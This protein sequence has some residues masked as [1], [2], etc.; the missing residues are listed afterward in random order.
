MIKSGDYASLCPFCTMW[1]TIKCRKCAKVFKSRRSTLCSIER[2]AT[3]SQF[4]SPISFPPRSSQNMTR[5]SKEDCFLPLNYYEDSVL[6]RATNVHVS[7]NKFH[8][9]VEK[10]YDE[11][12]PPNGSQ[13]RC[14]LLLMNESTL[15]R[16]TNTLIIFDVDTNRSFFGPV[17]LTNG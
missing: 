2:T 10:M 8:W 6:N 5:I 11:M 4:L 17:F 7:A 15:S 16:A 12:L 14:Q 13:Q 1:Q 3:S 9:K